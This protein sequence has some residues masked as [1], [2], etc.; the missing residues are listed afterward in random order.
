MMLTFPEQRV[1][2]FPEL[3]GLSIAELEHLSQREDRLDEFID[4]LRLVQKLNI[5]V[6]DMISKNEELASGY[7]LLH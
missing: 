3:Q 6:E 4:K 2:S 7:Y 5:T 1:L